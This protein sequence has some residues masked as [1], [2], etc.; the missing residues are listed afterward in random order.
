MSA[1]VRFL[2]VCSGVECASL[3]ARR[4]TRGGVRVL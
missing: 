4:L 2:S 3:A 1:E